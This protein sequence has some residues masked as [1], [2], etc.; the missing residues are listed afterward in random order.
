[1]TPNERSYI[2]NWGRVAYS[3]K[4][5]KLT[6]VSIDGR[7]IG[8]IF[9]TFTEENNVIFIAKV[10][11]CDGASTLRHTTYDDADR[12]IHI[13]HLEINRHTSFGAYLDYI[14]NDLGLTKM[15]LAKILN[16]SRQSVHQWSSNQSLPSVDVFIRLGRVIADTTRQN[17]NTILVDMAD[18]I[19]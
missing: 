7:V 18:S 12:W 9:A 15:S 2:K 16:V 3:A 19:H 11:D 17:L 14:M 1:M 4:Q 8:E 6:H 5:P 13:R 10:L